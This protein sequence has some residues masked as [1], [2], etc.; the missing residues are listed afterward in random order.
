MFAGHRIILECCLYLRIMTYIFARN[1][2]LHLD[3]WLKILETRFKP[4]DNERLG[5]IGGD[6][7]LVDGVFDQKVAG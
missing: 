7:A 6:V 5:G 4:L 1:I 3:N 2:T